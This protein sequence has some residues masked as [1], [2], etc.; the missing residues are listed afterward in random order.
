MSK[1]IKL[2]KSIKDKQKAKK[3][4]NADAEEIQAEITSDIDLWMEENDFDDGSTI[5]VEN[6]DADL[7]N[8]LK[9]AHR[10]NSDLARRTMFIDTESK[11][12]RFGGNA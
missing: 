8:D 2:P 6:M 3:T 4:D 11:T 5:E 10:S 9:R 1:K 12:V 7:V